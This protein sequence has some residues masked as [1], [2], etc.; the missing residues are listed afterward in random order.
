MT[1][2]LYDLDSGLK[3]FSAV[4]RS[5]CPVGE[6]F[7]ILLDRTAFFPEGGGQ[8]SD[9]G[10]LGDAV[11]SDVQLRA[12]E[13]VHISD[14]PLPEGARVTGVLDWTE[15]FRK[16]QNHS[17]EHIVSG[18]IHRMFGFDNVGFRLGERE[19][20][21]DYNGVLSRDM[22]DR[23]EEAANRAVW[24]NREIVCRY[25]SPEELKTLTYRSKKELSGPVRI[26]TVDGVDVCACCAPHVKRTGE[27][28]GILIQNRMK[29]KRGTRIFV[30]CGSDALS[31]HQRLRRDAQAVSVLCSAPV[32]ET[33][34]A[35]QQ[36]QLEMESLRHRIFEL[37]REN[38]LFRLR[39]MDG[40][41]SPCLFFS[42]ADVD[43]MRFAADEGLKLRGG[44]F[45]CAVGTDSDGYR[46][47]LRS[48]TLPLRS[49]SQE[50]F[51]HLNG[52]GGGSDRMLQG[53]FAA[54]EAQIREY[55]SHWI[56][57][58]TEV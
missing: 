7:E 45:L 43:T 35:V 26:V 42:E 50:L 53:R 28:G 8:R 54:S 47:L 31:E 33:C 18:L 56:K 14:R 36:L 19:M 58:R 27:I 57:E 17:G 12:G 20:T 6:C 40:G 13:I 39:S 21:M 37:S 3:V 30:R 11:V 32:G 16:M 49:L 15:R 55:F 5:C 51:Q 23:V 52:T 48:D 10:R 25:P 34:G 24:E 29:W 22:L 1:E 4:V 44:G 46:F 2:K 41:E 38:A 9:R